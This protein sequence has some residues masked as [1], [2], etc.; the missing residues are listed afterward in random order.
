MPL[1]PL[2]LLMLALVVAGCGVRPSTVAITVRSDAERPVVLWFYKSG[3]DVEG[4]LMSP[5]TYAVYSPPRPDNEGVADLPAV[6]LRPGDTVRL[7]ERG[8]FSDQRIPTL[9]VF[10]SA[11]TL[12]AMAAE[13]SES[14][15]VARLPMGPGENFVVVESGLPT[16]AVRVSQGAFRVSK[17]AP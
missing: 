6:E 11:T 12:T 17:Q 3:P 13:P 4:H 2:L 9:A 1:R 8:R 15:S 14:V 16:R 10:G 5:G 7:S